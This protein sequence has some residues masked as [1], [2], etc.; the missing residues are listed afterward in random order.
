MIH[1][2]KGKITEKSQGM[3]V[4]ECGG[5]GY[6]LNV[7]LTSGFYVADPGET[8]TAYTYMAVRE[9]DISLFGFDDRESLRVFRILTTVSGVGS[10]AALA[11]LSALSVAE[12]KR[13]IVMSE[14]EVLAKAQGVGKKTAQRI[15]VDLKDKFADEV[16]ADAEQS[17]EPVRTAGSMQNAEDTVEALIALGYSKSEASAAVRKVGAKDMESA[18]KA[19]RAALKQLATI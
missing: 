4:V 1:Y 13:A 8:V 3:V 19:L 10:K 16:G 17:G 11:I 7:P 2:I 14:P 12:I 9:D 15:V 5:I 18:E 6:E